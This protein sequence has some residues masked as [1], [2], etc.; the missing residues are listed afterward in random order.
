[1]P[2]SFLAVDYRLKV[3]AYYGILIFLGLFLRPL[4]EKFAL[5]E[6]YHAVTRAPFRRMMERE[7]ARREVEFRHKQ[8]NKRYRYMRYLSK[9]LPPKW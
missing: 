7:A 5:D 3:A 8:H 4:I 9:E 6:L 2:V 1:M